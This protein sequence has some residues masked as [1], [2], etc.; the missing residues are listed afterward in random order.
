MGAIETYRVEK[1]G[2]SF[3]IQEEMV[4][5][6]SENGYKVFKSFEREIDVEGQPVEAQESED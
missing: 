2:L 4:P 6:Y 3:F 5:Y 1:D